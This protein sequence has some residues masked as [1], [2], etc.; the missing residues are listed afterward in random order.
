M[1]EK[2]CDKCMHKVAESRGPDGARIVD[3]EINE[4]QMYSPF[5]EDCKHWEKADGREEA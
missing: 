2:N 3:C 5:A 1:T 4:F